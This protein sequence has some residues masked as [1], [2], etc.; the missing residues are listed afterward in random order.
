VC[1][2]HVRAGHSQPALLPE[3]H[4]RQPN[5][6]LGERVVD[7]HKARSEASSA[8]IRLVN[9]SSGTLSHKE[10]EMLRHAYTLIAGKCLA[11]MPTSLMPQ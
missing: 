10:L 9:E 5:R 8:A 4:L 1:L 11:H 7:V 6:V 3:L 2:G